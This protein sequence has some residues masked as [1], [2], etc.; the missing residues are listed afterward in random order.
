ML[1]KTQ[2]LREQVVFQML[3]DRNTEIINLTTE[4]EKVKIMYNESQQELKTM[5]ERS[6]GLHDKFLKLEDSLKLKADIKN[7]RSKKIEPN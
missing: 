5:K 3:T 6:Q 4:L 7:K 1:D 2:L